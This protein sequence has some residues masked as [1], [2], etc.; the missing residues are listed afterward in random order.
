MTKLVQTFL[1]LARS[2]KEES[3]VSEKVTL[4]TAAEKQIQIWQEEFKSK[5][6]QLILEKSTNTTFI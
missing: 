5:G 1:I 6:L 4:L 3:E 2:N